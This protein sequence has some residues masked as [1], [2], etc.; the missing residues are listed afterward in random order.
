MDELD[1]KVLELFHKYQAAGGSDDIV[2]MS[3]T[4]FDNNMKQWATDNGYVHI[5]TSVGRNVTVY[6]SDNDEP[7]MTEQEWREKFNG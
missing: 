5:P 6:T 7:L 3:R 4:D 1:A 2:I